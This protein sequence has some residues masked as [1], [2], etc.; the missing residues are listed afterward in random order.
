VTFLLELWVPYGNT[1][2]PVKVP[3]DNFYR[4]I[5]G[6]AK[7]ESVTL[8]EKI[9]QAIENPV[10][11]FSLDDMAKGS[12]TAG[13][14]IDPLLSASTVQT[15]LPI[16]KSK[17]QN[18]GISETR[19]FVR[20]RLSEWDKSGIQDEFKILDPEAASFVE[21]G[22]TSY[23]TPVSINDSFASSDVRVALTLVQPHY[24]SGFVGG[25][26]IV[27]P[28]LSSSTTITRNR[29]LSL[30]HGFSHIEDNFENNV[31]FKDSMEAARLVGPIYGITLIPD[32]QGG[33][34]NILAGDL[35]AIFPQA[36]NAYSEYHKY[37]F[38]RKLDIV[39]ISAGQLS[40][41][42]L[43][44][45]IRILSNITD[46]LRKDGTIILVAQCGN[47][48]GEQNF[49]DYAKKFQEKKTL[50]S[51]LRY[52]FRLGAHVNLFLYELLDK[53]KIELVS[54]LPDIYTHNIFQLKPCRTV[55][56]AVQKA[57]RTQ[58]KESKILLIE[59]GDYTL[60]IIENI[61]KL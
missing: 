15:L 47:G 49:V 1:E 6:K 8:F 9:K 58:G 51:E 37:K 29:S 61:S 11:G 44:H 16:V 43:Y 23:G 4:I 31:V 41:R 33:I 30:K 12:R 53:F 42:D 2:V 5:S 7:T 25:P 32:G 56:E 50:V 14:I 59:K 20:K 22:K 24:I 55:S 35:M 52:R 34:K 48:I 27:L 19:F 26:D 10:N 17:L 18:I 54:G 38:E 39:I 57:I 40:G 28:G 36:I 60:P 3:D 21:L 13:I 45:A 46:I